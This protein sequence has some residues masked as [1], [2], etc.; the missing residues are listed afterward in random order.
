MTKF[1]RGLL[2]GKLISKDALSLLTSSK[3]RGLKSE[4]DYGYGF[5]LGNEGQTRSFGHGGI[6]RGVNFA[7][8][9]FPGEDL[10][11]VLFNNQDNGAYDDLRKNIIKLITGYR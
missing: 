8:R 3:V 4:T 10:T 11:L 9:Y 7:Y 2:T 1:S 6:T 5:E